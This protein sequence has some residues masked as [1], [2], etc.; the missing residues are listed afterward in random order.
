MN[1]LDKEMYEKVVLKEELPEVIEMEEGY[2]QPYADSPLD[3][4]NVG[5]TIYLNII[6][7]A[8][9]YV[10][11]FTPLTGNVTV[12][13]TVANSLSEATVNFISVITLDLKYVTTTSTFDTD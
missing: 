6:S 5:E 12:S 9:D 7:Q 10:Y 4:E 1:V 8:M 13:I 2:V 11:I 3:S